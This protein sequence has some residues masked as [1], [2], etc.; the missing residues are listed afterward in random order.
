MKKREYI[1]MAA[2]AVSVLSLI[3]AGLANFG[4]PLMG[5]TAEGFSRLCS[6]VALIT[7]AGGV[8]FREPKTV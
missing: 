3:L 7:I 6:N 4:D 8:W 5:V 1:A 2:I